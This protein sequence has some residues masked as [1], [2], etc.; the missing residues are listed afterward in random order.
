MTTSRPANR[1]PSWGP[2]NR[3]VGPDGA[4]KMRSF[5]PRRDDRG[6]GACKR[7]G[8]PCQRGRRAALHFVDIRRFEGRVEIE[9]S[10]MNDVLM[11]PINDL[12]K[13]GIEWN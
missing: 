3:L 1:Y 10:D 4:G 6:N 11:V 12:R 8:G 5:F 9:S 2:G 7:G 13:S